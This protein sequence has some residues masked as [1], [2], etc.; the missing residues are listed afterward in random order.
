MDYCNYNSKK[1]YHLI[2]FVYF[3][4]FYHLGQLMKINKQI[5]TPNKYFKWNFSFKKITDKIISNKGTHPERTV[6]VDNLK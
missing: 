4:V 6:P 2:L 1:D 5:K 3:E